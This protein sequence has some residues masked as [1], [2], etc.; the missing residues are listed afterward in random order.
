M[1]VYWAIKRFQAQPCPPPGIFWYTHNR[2]WVAADSSLRSLYVDYDQACEILKNHKHAV[3]GER[4]I[5]P[6]P[7]YTLV[8][9]PVTDAP[10]P[11]IIVPP[12][13]VAGHP[14]IESIMWGIKRLDPKHQDAD[15]MVPY[16]YCE[17]HDWTPDIR[18]RL[19]YVRR[20]AA[21]AALWSERNDWAKRN[22]D[23]STN[24]TFSLIRVTRRYR[25]IKGGK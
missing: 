13:T 9:L 20:L 15:E 17:P 19:L 5:L 10:L 24:V 8:R 21:Q 6:L 18:D 7:V 4:Q 14:W 11:G 23:K 2:G 12:D 22:L 25:A 3:A 16:Y 1:T